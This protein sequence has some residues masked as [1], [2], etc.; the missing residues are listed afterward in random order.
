MH[1]PVLLQESLAGLAIQ[2]Q[3]TYVDLTFGSGGHS[4]AILERLHGGRLIAFDQDPA[5]AQAAE[6]IRNENF[7]FIRANARFMQQ[8]LAF[9]GARQVDGILVD[10]GVSSYQ[11]DTPER[12]FS[13]RWDGVLDMRMDPSTVLTAQE[14]VNTYTPAQLQR[15]FQEYGEVRN[16]RT[17]AHKIVA[18]RAQ[19]PI[20]TTQA[21]RTILTPLAPNHRTAKYYAQVFQALRIAVNGELEALKAILQQSTDVLKVGGRLVILSYH[22]LEDR[23]VKRFMHAGN[24]EGEQQKDVYGH[25]ER[26]LRPVLRKA[27]KPTA[28]EINRNNRA[29]SARMRVGEKT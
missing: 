2:P 16:A 12:G 8:F 22:S 17:L 15:L 26:P 18:V 21:L 5:A 13:T 28:A 4:R 9:H 25:V 1:T 10:L 6:S 20:T 24:F 7:I 29:R 14:I 23:L 11:I 19:G 3:G 27:M